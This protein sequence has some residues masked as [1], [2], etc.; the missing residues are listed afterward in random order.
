MRIHIVMCR[1]EVV[2]GRVPTEMEDAVAQ[3]RREVIG[4]CI[5]L[6]RCGTNGVFFQSNWPMSMMT[7]ERSFSLTVIQQNRT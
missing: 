5:P 1:T 4:W 2:E 3:R 6:A 7:W